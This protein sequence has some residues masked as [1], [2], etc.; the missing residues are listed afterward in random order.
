VASSKPAMEGERPD[1]LPSGSQREAPVDIALCLKLS[2]NKPELA[3]DMLHMLL[4]DLP[5]D[6]GTIEAAWQQDQLPELESAVHR[7]NGGASYCGVPRLKASAALLD[8][9]LQSRQKPGQNA[10][11]DLLASIDELLGWQEEHDLD[12]LF[13]LE[14][15][16]A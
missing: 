16:K 2:N 7:L 3:R 1:G 6:R 12:T 9:Q 13:G 8:S 14:A 5:T 10:V 11:E 15:Q 4:K